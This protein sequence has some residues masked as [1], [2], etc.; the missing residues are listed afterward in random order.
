M[1]AERH[2][3]SSLALL[4]KN[5]NSGLVA[6]GRFATMHC[7]FMP[8]SLEDAEETLVPSY[9]HFLL[10][11]AFGV[12]L[13]FCNFF[14]PRI[15]SSGHFNRAGGCASSHCCAKAALAALSAASY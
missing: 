5:L 11:L 9:F 13:S 8:T 4:P 7:K 12:P 2:N 6:P 1:A 10:T 14:S 15:F 3:D